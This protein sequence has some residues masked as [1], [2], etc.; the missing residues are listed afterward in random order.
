L[1]VPAA[2]AQEPPGPDA[3]DPIESSVVKIFARQSFPDTARPWTS[4]APSD[5]T[6]SGVVIEGRRIL[7]NAHVVL[8][9][10]QVQVQDEES[11]DKIS[12]SVEAIDPGIDLALLK[13]DGEA[14]FARHSSLSRVASLPDIRSPVMAY[15]YPNGGNGLSVTK[16]IVSRI[17]FVDYNYPVSGLRIQ[18]DAA[19]NPGDSGGPTVMDGKMVG[20]TFSALRGSQNIGYIIPDEEIELFLAAARGGRYQ[21]KP[22]MNDEFQTLENPALRQFLK[23]P[24]DVHGIVVARPYKDDKAYPLKRWDVITRIGDAPVDDQGMI[25]IK[26]GLRV[27]FLYEVQKAARDDTLPLVLYRQGQERHVDMPLFHDK[28]LLMD[29]FSGEY[30]SYFIFG[31]LVFAEASWDFL[32]SEV[33]GD[34]G[35]GVYNWLSQRGSPLVGRRGEGPA[36]RGERLVIVS[37]PLF[38]HKLSEGY[39]NPVG[40]VLQAVNGI[41]VK[42]LGHLVEILR[43]CR[44]D[45]VSFTFAE[46]WSE[47]IVLPRAEALAA[48]EGILDDN[49]IRN[50]GSSDMLAIWNKESPP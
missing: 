25:R 22:M 8:Y 31:P 10:R 50:Q 2:L 49:G 42:N 18:I 16:G 37:S 29:W 48:T 26:A 27:G 14:F 41:S 32:S 45:F 20:L 21:G 44:D 13:L 15:G 4:L 19:I 47:S 9:S 1:G 46:H 7:T 40:Q 35:V 36:F 23:L 28:P 38:P 3:R 24:G 33:S 6:G 11:G 30:P 43:D 17:E 39:G 34:N 12:A 5:V